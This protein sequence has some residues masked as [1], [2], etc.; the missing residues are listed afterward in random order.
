MVK[1]KGVNDERLPPG[2]ARM[3]APQS[4]P[5]RKQGLTADRVVQAAVELADADG[6]A[7]L[8]MARVAE[9]LGFT[10]M[11]LYRHVASKDELLVLMV[12]HGVGAPPPLDPAEGW[13]EQLETWSRALFAGVRAHPWILRI[14]LSWAAMGPNRAGWMEAVFGAM[15]GTALHE[16]EKAGVAM[17]LNGVAMSVARFEADMD[18]SIEGRTAPP[19]EFAAMVELMVAGDRFPALRRAVEAGVFSDD[20][21]PDED[22]EFQLARTLDGVAQLVAARAA[23]TA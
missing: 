17:M 7:A 10:T 21:G 14:P 12:D 16:S 20:D 22:F 15:A 9:R 13:R 2:V 1:I 5:A 18:L 4:R 8:S 6:L 19:E 11:S 23:A 3:W